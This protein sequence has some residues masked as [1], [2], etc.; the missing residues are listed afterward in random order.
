MRKHGR[1]QP[2]HTLNWSKVSEIKQNVR[3]LLPPGE[4]IITV[5]DAHGTFIDELRRVRNRIAH[6]NE[7]ARRSYQVIVK[8]HYGARVNAVTPGMLLL[9]RRKRP[10]LLR[11]YIRKSQVLVKTMTKG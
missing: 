1:A 9:T 4:H 11:Q 7:Q 8:R 2:R 6:N 3:H 10:C 5:L